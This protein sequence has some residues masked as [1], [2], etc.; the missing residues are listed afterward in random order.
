MFHPAEVELG[1]T[2]QRIMR[3]VRAAEPRR[4]A[5][6]SMTELRLLAQDPLQYRRQVMHLKEFFSSLAC[7]VLLLDDRMQEHGD[8]HL[9]SVV[10]GVIKLEQ[11]NPEYGAARRRLQ[12]L[13]LRGVGYAG[14]NHD[15]AIRRGGLHIFPRTAERTGQPNPAPELVSS[16]VAEIDLLAGGGFPAGSSTL[17]IGPAGSGKSSFATRFALTA[18]ER[19]QKAAFFLFDEST[20]MHQLRSRSLGM[21]LADHVAAGR[22]RMQHIDPG[23][24][25]PGEFAYRVRKEVEQADCRTVVIDSLNG[26]LNAAPAE[27]FLAVQLHELLMH[28]GACNVLTFLIVGQVGLLDAGGTAPVET[29]YLADNV[30]LFRYFEVRGEVRQALSVMKKRSGPHERTIRELRLGA[31]G[32]HVGPPLR[33][34][35]GV[36]TS[37]PTIL[38]DA[39]GGV[40][41]RV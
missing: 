15:F 29:S 38:G 5:L 28:L 23:E 6:D 11:L 10:N 34:F 35:Q 1:E 30:V 40:R 13:K 20:A 41:E 7:T 31:D 14:G 27:R 3:A 12:I 16:G 25:S 4:L 36:L 33:Q 19:G 39:P 8:T 22:V 24:M 32:L 26:Y 18:V 21:D 2:T 17:L 37:V 9:Q